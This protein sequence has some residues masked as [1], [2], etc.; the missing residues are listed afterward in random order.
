MAAMQVSWALLLSS[1]AETL[2][3]TS[4][5]RF[6]K[7]VTRL[8]SAVKELSTEATDVFISFSAPSMMSRR[9]PT[10]SSMS[11]TREATDFISVKICSMVV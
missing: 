5:T 7:S 10:D 4:S 1:V 11:F 2:S 6:S 3:S 8:D 9:A